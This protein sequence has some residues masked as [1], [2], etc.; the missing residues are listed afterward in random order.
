MLEVPNFCQD[1]SIKMI[2]T[3][4]I[5][6]CIIFFF[7]LI[8]LIF[9]NK[10]ISHHFNA[11]FLEKN[12]VPL[13]FLIKSLRCRLPPIKSKVNVNYSRSLKFPFFF[14]FFFLKLG[15]LKE[16][17]GGTKIYYNLLSE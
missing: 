3:L 16:G 13:T 8:V 11:Y 6:I 17:K 7:L 4:L 12:L 9:S 15:V 14:F 5:S 10:K 2:W 1:M